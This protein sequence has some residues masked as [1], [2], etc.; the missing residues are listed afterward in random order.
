MGFY[1]N[2]NVVL[3]GA[4]GGLGIE[5]AKSLYE[6]KANLK[7]VVNNTSNTD[8]IISIGEIIR[9]DLSSSQAVNELIGSSV[10]DDVDI[11][12]NCA[13]SW[14]LSS[15][16]NSSEENYDRLMNLNTKTPYLLAKACIPVMKNKAAGLIINIGSSSCYNGSD[17][18]GIYCVSKHALLGLSR[19]LSKELKKYKIRVMMFSP[20]SIRTK[21]GMLDTR[22]DFDSFLDPCEV[23]EFILFSAKYQNEMILDEVRMNRIE[24]I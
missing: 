23:S 6:D 13:G 24:T 11:L 17:E 7:M 8:S 1:T 15:I 20:G 19:S 2:K 18:T 4:S 10:F 16:E 22:Q 12:I 3:T 9:C 5:L 21:M 14:L